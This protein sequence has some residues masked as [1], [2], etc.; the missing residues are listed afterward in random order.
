MTTPARRLRAVVRAVAPAPAP[1][2]GPAGPA[3]ATTPAPTPAAGPAAD[4]TADD[5]TLTEADLRFFDEMGY[6]VIKRA[7]PRATCRRV[8]EEM[9]AHTGM[10]EADATTWHEYRCEGITRFG[11]ETG[12]AGQGGGGGGTMLNM[13]TT[14]GM[15][16]LRTS[17]RIHRA[18]S[19]LWDTHKLWCSIDT[20]DLKP[21]L[22]AEAFPGWGG[23]LG[24]HCDLP[25]EFLRGA[26]ARRDRRIQ[27]QVY[28]ADTTDRGGGFRCIPGFMPPHFDEW[29]ATQ[30]EGEGIDFNKVP[31]Q[32]DFAVES[33][34]AEAGDMVVWNSYLP[35]GNGDNHE[36][37][38]RLTA[39]C[40]MF[41]AEHEGGPAVPLNGCK[42]TSHAATVLCQ[43]TPALAGQT[44]PPATTRSSAAAGCACGASACPR[45]ATPGRRSRPT[46][47]ARLPKCARRRRRRS[48]PSGASCSG[49]SAGER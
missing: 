24:L 5:G 26:A 28:L 39:Y 46:T 15:W 12:G 38:C 9:F 45:A 25:P 42:R 18:M 43:L 27:G 35:H 44:A 19:Q 2:A 33:I 17:P 16:D 32:T 41:P 29:I 10:D 20:C 13:W 7:V 21:P 48:R 3:L 47:R 49:S 31:E 34:A 30:P 14:Q 36:A 23:A 8:I 40:T 22:R 4:P 1:A 11:S 6:L 37:S